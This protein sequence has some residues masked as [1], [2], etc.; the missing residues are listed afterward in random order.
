LIEDGFRIEKLLFSFERAGFNDEGEEPKVLVLKMLESA[1][2]EV[3]MGT[4]K[5]VL[6]G[7]KNFMGI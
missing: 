7:Y 3:E 1:S 2:F 5:L 4:G 6:S